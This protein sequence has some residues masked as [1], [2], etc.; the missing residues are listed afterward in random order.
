[1]K[2]NLTSKKINKNP[3][4]FSMM[5]IVIA[6]FLISTGL[7]VAVELISSGVASSMNSRDQLI[8]TELAQEGLELVRNMRDNNWAKGDDSFTHI[9]ADETCSIDYTQDASQMHCPNSLG[10]SK[11]YLEDNTNLYT[12]S[13]SATDTKFHR[14]IINTA[15]GSDMIITSLVSWDGSFPES[16][17]ECTTINKCVYAQIKLTTWGE[18]L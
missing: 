4:G 17:S 3:S 10:T 9:P 1:M 18:Q 15:S 16:E 2:K 14:N 11:L 5:E 7:I 8:A 12:C 6:V 13:P